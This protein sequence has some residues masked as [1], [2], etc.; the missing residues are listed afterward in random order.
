MTPASCDENRDLLEYDAEA[1]LDMQEVSRTREEGVTVIDLTYAIPMGG[2]VPA[3]LVV[4]DGAGPF[5]GMLCQHGM[6]ST[7][8]PLIPAAIAYARAGAVV[9]LIDAPFARRA[10]GL[11][12]PMTCTDQDRR[13]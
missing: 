6:P 12:V 4:P 2:R 1:P 8:Q 10:G 5:A 9:L 3:T 11:D 7:R 13:Q